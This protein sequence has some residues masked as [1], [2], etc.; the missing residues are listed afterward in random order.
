MSG[1]DTPA[2][3]PAEG[4][5]AAG[6]SQQPSAPQTPAEHVPFQR[7]GRREVNLQQ[8]GQQQQQPSGGDANGDGG[9]ATPTKTDWGKLDWESVDWSKVDWD[10]VSIPEIEKVPGVSKMQSALRKQANEA[11]KSAQKAS[12][13]NAALKAQLDELTKLVQ[14]KLPQQSADLDRITAMSEAERMR[15]ELQAYQ[16]QEVTDRFAQEYGLPNN[17]YEGGVNSPAELYDKAIDFYRNKALETEQ[18]TNSRLDALQ[19][20]LDAL[21]SQG[22]D[23]A[24]NADRGGTLGGSVNWQARYDQAASE[25]NGPEADSIERQA[26]AQGVQID[27]VTAWRRRSN[28]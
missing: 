8:E 1:T 26:T 4:A 7:A 24:A 27:T 3:P 28:R 9:T 11:A 17:L 20:E 16:Q 10:K 5:G 19:K 23:P 18:S 13:E 25:G 2:T 22:T 12:A 14:G 15:A 6:E 21:K